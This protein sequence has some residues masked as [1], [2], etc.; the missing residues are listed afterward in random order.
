M[1]Y[2]GPPTTRVDDAPVGLDCQAAGTARKHLAWCGCLSADRSADLFFL[3]YPYCQFWGRKHTLS[4]ESEK[5]L[6]QFFQKNYKFNL[7][8]YA[9]FRLFEKDDNTTIFKVLIIYC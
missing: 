2:L 6:S 7:L 1:G 5:A 9:I 8:N 3:Y 4:V